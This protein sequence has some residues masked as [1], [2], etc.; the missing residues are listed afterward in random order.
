[1]AVK[2][3]QEMIDGAKQT[4]SLYGVPTSITLGQ[5][6]LESGGSNEGGL[7]TLAYK[8][9]NLFGVTA[10]SSWKGETVY[11]TNKNGTDGQTY[12]VYSSIMD[13]IIDHGK[14]L[15]TDRYTKNT[16]NAKTIEQYAQAIKNSGY[17]TDPEYVSKL[18]SVIKS[19]NLTSYDL[20]T[21]TSGASEGAGDIEIGTTHGGG[22]YMHTA[23]DSNDLKW[24]GDII[25][26][27]LSV[28]LIA[29]GVVFF[30]LAFNGG[31]IKNVSTNVTDKVTG[32]TLSKI[33]KIGR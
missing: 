27:I 24:W 14:L 5:I 4:E 11:M 29:L 20:G 13:S 21:W 25:V 1:M 17:A 23:T 32:G 2:L 7:S 26:V 33:K 28:L 3:T 12:R 10:G 15:N 30:V 9:N 8:Y 18:L 19:N 22:G 31:S 6:M 16:K